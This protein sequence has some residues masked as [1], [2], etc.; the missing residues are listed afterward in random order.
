MVV[1]TIQHKSVYEM[2]QK[3]GVYYPDFD[4]A[5][6]QDHRRQYD[7]LLQTFKDSNVHINGVCALRGLVFCF[8]IDRC[9][10]FAELKERS[11][12]LGVLNQGRYRLLTEEYR[13]LRISNSAVRGYNFM[14]IYLANF[15]EL[16]S[17]EEGFSETYS[18]L[19]QPA[20]ALMPF[21][22]FV[23][24]QREALYS[25]ELLEPVFALSGQLIQI[26]MPLLL[27][28]HIDEIFPAADLTC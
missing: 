4:K 21:K 23:V 26:H 15:I 13:L 25:G 7:F 24:R 27:A 2:I 11:S 18:Q 3:R 12:S 1:W 19:A 6:C 17:E 8:L 9:D 22:E 5:P 20:Y 28:S 14:P 16:F 10:T